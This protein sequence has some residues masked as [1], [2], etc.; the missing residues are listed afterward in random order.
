MPGVWLVLSTKGSVQTTDAASAEP[1]LLSASFPSA[2]QGRV[3]G[4]NLLGSVYSFSTAPSASSSQNRAGA[5]GSA[6]FTTRTR[7]PAPS[8]PM[9]QEVPPSSPVAIEEIQGYEASMGR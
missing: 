5:S 2:Y 9:R 6:A 7:N 8:A 3:R 1:A 4:S